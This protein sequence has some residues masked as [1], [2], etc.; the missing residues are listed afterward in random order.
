MA[1]HDL[2]ATQVGPSFQQVR[3][4]TVTQH[5]G[6]KSMKNTGLSA[7]SGQQLP[8]GLAREATAPGGYEKVPAGA[9]LEQRGAPGFEVGRDRPHGV[10]AGGHQPLL[11]SLTG[12]A[13]D[14]HI[15]IAVA[16]PETAELGHP[17]A[18]GVQQFQ[19]GAV[20]QAAVVGLPDAR[21]GEVPGAFVVPAP[22]AVLDVA[23][24]VDF[25][26]ERLAKF[27]VPRTVWV[28]DHLPLNAAG[29]VAKGELRAEAAHRLAS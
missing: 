29:K 16:Q 13:D 1:Q 6:R 15:Q 19:H 28:V 17:Q 2:Y 24:L 23:S 8:K 3:S 22:C 14:A 10:P 7:V 21:M 4:K 12:G 26:G 9:A 5:V 25:L 18:G 20:S 27:K 11:V